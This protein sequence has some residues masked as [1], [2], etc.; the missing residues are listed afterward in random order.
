MGP[1][2]YAIAPYAERAFANGPGRQYVYETVDEPTTLKVYPGRDGEFLLYDD[3]GKTLNHQKGDV[4]VTRMAWNNR[5]R[6]LT[7]E[8]HEGKK[9]QK[10]F[11]IN[12]AGSSKEKTVHYNGNQLHIKVN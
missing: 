8:P 5:E 7:L 9:F 12:I 3:D 10:Q 6:T 4:S 2:I 1:G 11:R